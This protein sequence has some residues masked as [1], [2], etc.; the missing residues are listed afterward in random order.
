MQA[1]NAERKFSAPILKAPVKWAYDQLGGQTATFAWAILA[2]GTWLALAEKLDGTY[3]AL[4][5]IVQALV[6]ARA[7]AEDKYIVREKLR[8]GNDSDHAP[9]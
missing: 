5:G 1:H 8:N 4:L 3:V 7:I 2:L 6:M 9:V